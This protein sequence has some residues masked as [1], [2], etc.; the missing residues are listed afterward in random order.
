M[1]K[2]QTRAILTN[3]ESILKKAGSSL[4]KVLKAN[5]WLHYE[6]GI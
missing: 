1:V 3:I 4:E 5:V 6:K 2:E